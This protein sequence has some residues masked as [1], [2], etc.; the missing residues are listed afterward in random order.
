MVRRLVIA[1]VVSSISAL[2]LGGVLVIGAG[3]FGAPGT[4]A[5]HDLNATGTVSDSTGAL[6][7]ISVDHGVQAFKMKGVGGP[8][9]ITGPQTVFNYSGNLGNGSFVGGCFIIP[10]SAFTVAAGLASA[11]LTVDPSIETPCPGALVPT[12]PGARSGLSGVV[13]FAGGGGGGIPVTAQLV[14]T[15]NGA[16][17]QSTFTN[18]SRCQGAAANSA[19]SSTS[20]FATL[21][22]SMSGLSGIQSLTASIANDSSVDVIT[23]TFPAPCV[24]P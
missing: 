10:D 13:P 19:G 2:I 22:G 24:G 23:A 15:S 6:I 4:T 11:R 1:T 16:I 12:V 18:S 3:G 9:V 5:S 7:S 20:T 17:M 21:S 8:P 14:W